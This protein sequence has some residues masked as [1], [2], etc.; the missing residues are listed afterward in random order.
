[1]GEG[2]IPVLHETAEVAYKESPA[3]ITGG[4]PMTDDTSWPSKARISETALRDAFSLFATGVAIVT[5]R[6]ERGQARAIT[7]SSFSSASLDPPLVLYCLGKSAFHFDVFAG[8]EA[9][10][11][12]VLGADQEALSN[13][14]AMEREDDLSDLEIA[15]LR[16]GSPIIKGCL[17]ALD[18]RTE[19][20]H[21]A[22]D[23]VIIVGRIQ[24]LT[25]GGESDPL[26]YFRRGYGTLRPA[27]DG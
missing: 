15:A 18:C 3:T 19:A 21:D 6:D 9:F 7:V 17:S 23:H 14:F 4:V 24:A 22:G 10:A 13:R 20:R 8:A 26:L 12:N 1:M 27:R 11:V 16:T 5:A 25:I 2:R